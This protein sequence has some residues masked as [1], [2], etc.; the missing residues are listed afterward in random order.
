[1]QNRVQFTVYLFIGSICNLG[2]KNLSL[3]KGGST[4]P[5]SFHSKVLRNE[6]H[7]TAAETLGKE[8]VNR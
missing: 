6:G 3:C 4:R 1:M 2:C 5:I 8:L 7:H